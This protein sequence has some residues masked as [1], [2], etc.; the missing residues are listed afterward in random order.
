MKLNNVSFKLLLGRLGR[1]LHVASKFLQHFECCIS[2]LSENSM[3]VALIFNVSQEKM[4][5]CID[6]TCKFSLQGQLG[7]SNCFYLSI[8]TKWVLLKVKVGKKRQINLTNIKKKA[9]TPNTQP[10][11]EE[12]LNVFTDGRETMC[13]KP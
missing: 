5:V 13:K 2:L 9:A 7:M 4:S 11:V 3:Q 8:L 10:A 1:I 6:A 12:K